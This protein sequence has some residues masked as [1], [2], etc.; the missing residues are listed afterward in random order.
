MDA[1]N[2][3]PQMPKFVLLIARQF[4]ASKAHPR[5]ADCRNLS[6]CDLFSM[7]P[8]CWLAAPSEYSVIYMLGSWQH[9][10]PHKQQEND[11]LQ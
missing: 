1:Q 9:F 10:I 2:T 5:L 11:V 4:L 7:L 3:W 6:L 8:P